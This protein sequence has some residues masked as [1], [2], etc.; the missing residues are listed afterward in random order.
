MKTT[1]TISDNKQSEP[2]ST[3]AKTFTY[4]KSEDEINAE[5]NDVLN[6]TL[7]KMNVTKATLDEMIESLRAYKKDYEA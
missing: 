2:T 5:L 6:S 3:S 7:A 1:T 4:T